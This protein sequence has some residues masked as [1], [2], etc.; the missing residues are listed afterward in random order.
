[1]KKIVAIVVLLSLL[2]VGSFIAIGSSVS[3]EK[4]NVT[5]KENIIY[6]DKLYAEGAT[7]FTRAHY[8]QRLFWDTAYTIG[9]TPKCSTEYEFRYS[10]RFEYG[11]RKHQGLTLDVD[12]KYG[13]DTTVPIEEST[14]LQKAYRELYDATKPGEKGVKKIRLQ[15]YYTYYPIRVNIDLPGVLWQGN[16]YENLSYDEFKNERIVWDKFNEFFKIPIPENLPEF[17]ISITKDS[18]GNGAGVG[19]SGHDYDYYLNTQTVYT[20]N[21]VFFS[22]GNTI[23]GKEDDEEKYVDTSLIPGGYGI[24]SFTYKNVRNATNTQGNNTTFYPGYETGVEQ[25]TLAMVFS[26]EQHA[27]VIY[28]TLSNDESKLLV[29][30]KEE[31]ITYLTIIEIA[32]MNE[33]QKLK[34]TEANQYLFYENDNCIVLN[35]WDYIS[36][37]EKQENG[38]CKLAFTVSRMKEIN[39][40]NH[41][42]GVATTMAFDGK[43]LIMVDRTAEKT[44][45]AL[46]LCGFSVAV[47][48]NSGL[49]YY[50]EYESSLSASADTN[51]Y[52]FNCL[53]VEYAVSW[54]K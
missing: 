3:Q 25:D 37:I 32:S 29:F 28:M 21:Q 6:G 12:F 43:K 40:S 52:A 42:K 1:M 17:E 53:P 22:I 13:F 35:G 50:A 27:E 41:Q 16:D 49:V 30:T 46:E 47:Y 24:Y 33:L 44:Y 36:V 51:D 7:V 54:D 31:G 5:I 19:S 14:G 18:H 23:S 20:E 34:I 45:G 4:E 15:D 10:P 11:E 8:D 2:S 48:N 26:L 38:L 9:N 39:D